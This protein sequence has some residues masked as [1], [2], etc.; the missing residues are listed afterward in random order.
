[1]Q[2]IGQ[3]FAKASGTIFGWNAER[4][5]KS[6]GLGTLRGADLS[7]MKFSGVDLRN[8]DLSGANLSNCIFEECDLSGVIINNCTTENLTISRSN[9]CGVDFS[10]TS[11]RAYQ[12]AWFPKMDCNT[13]FPDGLT[14]HD[15]YRTCTHGLLS[16]SGEIN[17][18]ATVPIQ[19][20][21]EAKKGQNVICPTGDISELEEHKDYIYRN[22][23]SYTKI[24]L[25]GDISLRGDDLTDTN[26]ANEFLI[27]ADFSAAILRGANFGNAHL[28]GAKFGGCDAQDANF[29]NACLKYCKMENGDFSRACFYNADLRGVDLSETTGITPL[30]L[31]WA[32]INE[33]TVLPEGMSWKDI[34]SAVEKH[35]LGWNIDEPDFTDDP[36]P[37]NEP[38]PVDNIGS[39][40]KGIEDKKM[41]QGL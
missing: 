21:L 41:A 38:D 6:L 7:G 1:M 22:K 37:D 14:R 30:Q 36:D 31:F 32:N 8:E 10:Q 15:I 39:G 4:L 19:R 16:T 9:I 12:F 27:D 18:D 28:I 29:E 40:K 33:D 20:M 24:H 11:M 2:K 3:L 13:K 17:E 26:F 35:L 23:R 25:Y 5:K 34:S